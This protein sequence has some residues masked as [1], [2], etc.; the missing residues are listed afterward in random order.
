MIK[1]KNK[2]FILFI[3]FLG[4]NRSEARFATIDDISFK[5]DYYNI[6]ANVNPDGSLEQTV[7]WQATI[8]KEQARSTLLDFT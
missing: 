8:L 4:L 5:Y 6:T 1:N 7:E 3:L 2:F